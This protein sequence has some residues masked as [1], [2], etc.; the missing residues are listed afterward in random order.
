[1]TAMRAPTYAPAALLASAVAGIAAGVA[2]LALQGVLP[3]AWNTLADSGAV[4]TVIAFA[5]AAALR[6]S[7]RLAVTSG[8]LVLVGE[9]FGYY[10][11][12]AAQQGIA[13]TVSEQVLWTVAALW[14]G[15]LAGLAGY[16]WRHGS[17]ARSVASGCGLAGVMAGEGLHALVRNGATASGAAELAAGAV[18]AVVALSLRRARWSERALAVGVGL[19]VVGLTFLA[20]GETVLS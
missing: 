12:A 17:P 3:G 5:T 9:V 20:Y 16:W 15:P 14:I 4:W 2:T 11:V 8:L 13:V 19:L 10:V 1:M 18:L 7:R 6:G